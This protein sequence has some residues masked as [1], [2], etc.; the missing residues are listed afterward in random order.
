M[1]AVE[2]APM[3]VAPTWLRAL[4]LGSL[5]LL[6][7]TCAA[8]SPDPALTE[9]RAAEHAQYLASVVAKDVEEVR[10]ALPQGVEHLVGLWKNEQDPAKEPE[11]ARDALNSARN[12]VQDLRLVKS[13]FFAL[14]SPDGTVIRNDLQQDMMA[15]QNLFP[16]FPALRTVGGTA[17]KYVETVGSMH[18]ARGVEGKPD[19]QWVAAQA[20]AIDSK[21][22]GLYVSGWTWSQYNY[23]L[24]TALKSHLYDLDQKDKPL[25]YVFVV[26]GKQAFGTRVSPLVN[27]EAIEKLDPISQLKDGAFTATLEIT[28]RSFGLAVRSAPELGPDIA[29]AVLRSET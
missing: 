18:E 16:A 9:R 5:A 29:V 1:P 17:G 10:V 11:R 23:R 27:A 21:V 6:W 7:I 20:I 24:E 3:Y 8:C 26:A 28:G 12:K 14:A 15:G 4:L 19:G 13:T 22:V 25:F 2:N